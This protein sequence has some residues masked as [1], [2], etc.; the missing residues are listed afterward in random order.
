MRLNLPEGRVIGKDD[1]ILFEALTEKTGHH[2]P[3][4]SQCQK[5]ILPPRRN[6]ILG[7]V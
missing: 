7:S 3:E 2:Q 6:G 5:G 4:Q 1:F